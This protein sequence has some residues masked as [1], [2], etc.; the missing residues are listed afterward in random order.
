MF[1]WVGEVG[2]PAVWFI[3]LPFSVI[4]YFSVREVEHTLAIHLAVLPSSLVITSVFEDVFALAMF[5]TVLHLTDVL[6]AV[7]ILFMDVLQFIIVLF[8]VTQIRSE[9]SAV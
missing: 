3:L 7:C 9:Y 6:V 2:A 8:L 1:L 5:Q 4:L